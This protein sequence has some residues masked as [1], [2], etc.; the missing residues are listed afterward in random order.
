MAEVDDVLA[1]ILRLRGATYVCL[2]DRSSGRI[3]SE[4]G[5]DDSVTFPGVVVRLDGMVS[6]VLGQGSGDEL[7]DLMI[8][9]RHRYHLVRHVAAAG[10]PPLLL[11]LRMQRSQANLAAARRELASDELN[12]RLTEAL[13]DLGGQDRVEGKAPTSG[14]SA[15]VRAP[16]SARP[17]PVG[18]LPAS[19]PAPRPVPAPR[20]PATRRPTA[21]HRPIPAP[22]MNPTSPPAPASPP[23]PAPGAE[24][25]PNAVLLPL[26]RRAPA[27]SRVTRMEREHE[28]DPDESGEVPP[29]LRQ[30][31]AFDRGTMER[32][33]HG[34]RRMMR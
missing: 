26:P 30:S 5:Y 28:P 22:R 1:E 7:E 21:S 16:R 24:S 33:V 17:N 19:I 6:D 11:Y 31:W 4:A 2:A 9:S 25:A 23:D 32:L 14:E 3:V 29:V 13:R 18:S 34:L 15:R 20:S 12:N 10:T 8:S 27:S